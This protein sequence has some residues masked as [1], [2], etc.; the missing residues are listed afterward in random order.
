[1]CIPNNCVREQ[2]FG[3]LRDYYQ[4]QSS[5]DLH[6]LNVMLTDLAYDGQWKPFFES[7]ALA[8]R[9]NSSVR[10]A[11]EGEKKS[12]RFSEGISGTRFLLSGRT[13]TGNELRLLR[14]LFLLP[15]KKRYPDIGHSYILS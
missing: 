8:Y 12:A 1:M 11:M 9:E 5:I 13:G 14:F 15:D 7:I 10:D 6:Y 4:K 3:F 2:Y